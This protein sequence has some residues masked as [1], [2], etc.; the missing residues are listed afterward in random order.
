MNLPVLAG[1]VF[2]PTQ[3]M[4][5]VGLPALALLVPL[6][7]ML[8]GLVTGTIPL[9]KGLLILGLMVT[10]IVVLFGLALEGSGG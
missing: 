6:W 5:C 2:L 8:K 9:G 7:W 1:E 4:V 3:R 10:L